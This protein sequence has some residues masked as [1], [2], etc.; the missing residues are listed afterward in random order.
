GNQNEFYDPAQYGP[1][2]SRGFPGLR[3]WLT[4]K[5]FGAER[6]RAA[7]K[8]KRDLAVWAAE[9]I[10]RIPGIVMDAPPQLSLFAFHLEGAGLETIEAQNAATESLMHRVTNRGQLMLSGAM[11]GNRY[12]GRV[13]VLSFRTRRSQMEMCVQQLTEETAALLAHAAAL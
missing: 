11:A 3:V 10:S 2:L 1:E 7:L 13:C 9:R 4:I 5:I 12:L 6:Y 8:E